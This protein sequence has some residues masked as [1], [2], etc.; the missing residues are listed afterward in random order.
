MG[1]KSEHRVTSIIITLDHISHLKISIKHFSQQINTSH[2]AH[3]AHGRPVNKSAY[4][5]RPIY[6]GDTPHRRATR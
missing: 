3:R 4:I 5:I 6:T 1:L 2:I